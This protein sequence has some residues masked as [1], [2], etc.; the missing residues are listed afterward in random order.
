MKPNYTRIYLDIIKYKNKEKIVSQELVK[1]INNIKIV[2]DILEIEKELF[3]DNYLRQ[4]QKLKSYDEP[5]I[6]LIL[7]YQKKNQL[8]N[9][10]LAKQYNISRNTI[11]RW[12][13]NFN[14]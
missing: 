14:K 10:E 12:K 1:K 2:K 7:K 3:K 5:T 13:K 4:N 6:K 8:T 11:A 9:L